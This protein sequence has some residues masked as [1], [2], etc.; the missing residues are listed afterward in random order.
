M[1]HLSI[2]RVDAIRTAQEE[3]DIKAANMKN[4]L[5]EELIK[6]KGQLKIPLRGDGKDSSKRES[7]E[8]AD[9]IAE[10]EEERQAKEDRIRKES[11]MDM[12]KKETGEKTGNEVKS[13]KLSE[14]A[15]TDE[16]LGV[17]DIP[18]ESN[19]IEQRQLN[20]LEAKIADTRES[21]IDKESPDKYTD[22][23]KDTENSGI[24]KIIKTERQK[25]EKGQSGVGPRERGENEVKSYDALLYK[26]IEAEASA[27]PDVTELDLI[28]NTGILV[29]D[30]KVE[31]DE[32][33]QS[34]VD[35]ASTASECSAEFTFK[36]D[37]TDGNVC[38]E[39]KKDNV[40]SK[41]VQ[42][43]SSKRENVNECELQ[44]KRQ[45][46]SISE[47]DF[48]SKQEDGD[49][50]EFNIQEIF[51]AK[52]LKHVERPP[53]SGQGQ[54]QTVSRS[55]GV[56]NSASDD[57]EVYIAK[58]LPELAQVFE[59]GDLKPKRHSRRQDGSKSPKPGGSEQ[60]DSS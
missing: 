37:F 34:S 16:N 31:L 5:D 48:D 26:D 44:S 21:A 53:E 40:S 18:N 13:E 55:N 54:G 58:S 32:A 28:Q 19:G 9:A 50:N 29:P 60:R 35:S 2:S 51:G 41:V 45:S 33:D 47:S 38:S 36:S 23:K 8:I 24:K 15:G 14:S 10:I 20:L 57:D 46:A 17:V 12:K 25:I 27:Y 49:S 59:P 52:Q 22:E 30:V 56:D 11:A 6:T 7:R 42:I 3:R 4:P 1:A 43:K 39:T